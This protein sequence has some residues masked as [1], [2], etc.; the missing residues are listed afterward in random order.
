MKQ[1]KLNSIC[2]ALNN[3]SPKD[4]K[5]IEAKN[6]LKIMQKTFTRGEKNY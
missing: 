6:S 4:K 2:V 5:Y 1:N 3:Y